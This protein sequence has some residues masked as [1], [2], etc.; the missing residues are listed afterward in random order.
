MERDLELNSNV[1]KIQDEEK[2]E[3]FGE[4]SI[5]C[6]GW[7][8]T[9]EL[10][11]SVVYLIV[12]VE[13]DAV[14][15]AEFTI[16]DSNSVTRRFRV[17]TFQ[18][19]LHVDENICCLPLHIERDVWTM[20]PVDLAELTKKNYARSTFHSTTRV[21]IHGNCRLRRVFFAD[22]IY[23]ES[24]L[25]TE[26]RMWKPEPKILKRKLVL[27]TNETEL[28]KKNQSKIETTTT[29]LITTNTIQD[30]NVVSETEQ[31][32]SSGLLDNLFKRPSLDEF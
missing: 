21:Q 2:E 29:T 25:P 14:F 6:P 5:V 12:K 8:K 30:N 31:Q 22:K 16:L 10:R 3:E 4:S 17:S 11:L 20:I 19:E 26:F 15:T 18:K 24:Q 32:Q 9:L 23:I 13:K 27:S 28:E 1:L 7:Q